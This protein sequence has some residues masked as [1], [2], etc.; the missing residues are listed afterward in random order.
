M[1][2]DNHQQAPEKSVLKRW[3]A[4][5]VSQI[6]K[7]QSNEVNLLVVLINKY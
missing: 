2:L 1:P 5:S 6:Q 4:Y 7:S 3:N